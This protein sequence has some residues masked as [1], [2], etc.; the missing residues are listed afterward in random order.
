ME[1]KISGTFI[2]PII[3][4]CL[5]GSTY[6][7]FIIQLN[8]NDYKNILNWLNKSTTLFTIPWKP[9]NHRPM[10]LNFCSSIKFTEQ[11]FLL[12]PN[13]QYPVFLYVERTFCCRESKKRRK[14]DQQ[15]PNWKLYTTIERWNMDSCVLG[16]KLNFQFYFICIERLVRELFFQNLR[17]SRLQSRL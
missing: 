3:V 12:P 7:Y 5:V 8:H 13:I 6:F 15:E 14:R 1:L 4:F 2:V 10:L 16:C 9:H 17:F 11:N